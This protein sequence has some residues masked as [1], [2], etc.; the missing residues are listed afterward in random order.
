VCECRIRYTRIVPT[1]GGIAGWRG[2]GRIRTRLSTRALLSSASALPFSNARSLAKPNR[3]IGRASSTRRRPCLLGIIGACL[4]GMN[5]VHAR[6]RSP[7][8]PEGPCLPH[9]PTMLRA[10]H[11]FHHGRIV[12]NLHAHTDVAPPGV[13]LI[14]VTV[15]EHDRRSNA[16]SSCSA[17]AHAETVRKRCS[18]PMVTSPTFVAWSWQVVR[19]EKCSAVQMDPSYTMHLTSSFSSQG[20]FFR[21]LPFSWVQ[22]SLWRR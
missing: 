21:P 10:F 20:E 11:S 9:I 22:L 1:G 7:P 12:Q 15:T 8:T 16:C 14:E 2:G 3:I 17:Y 6:L 5:T 4:N 18:S 19:P 13:D